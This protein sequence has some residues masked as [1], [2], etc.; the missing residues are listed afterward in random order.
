MK[1]GK[2]LELIARIAPYEFAGKKVL[3]AQPCH[4]VRDEGV[5]SRSGLKVKAVKVNSLTEITNGFDVIGI[6][7]INM[8]DEADVKQVYGWLKAGK[9]VVISGLDLSYKGELIPLVCRLMELKPDVMIHKLAVCEVC[10]NYDAK[11]T[12]ILHKG[13][14]VLEGLP[15]VTPEDGT[16]AYEPRCR[17]CFVRIGW[18]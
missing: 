16:Y 18:E 4:N 13:E 15:I 5:M 8:F 11:F 1:S 6:D 12:Q 14:P 3:Y 7:E 9:E 2:S 10:L 17:E